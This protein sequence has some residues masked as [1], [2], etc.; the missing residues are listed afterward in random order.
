MTGNAVLG[1]CIDLPRLAREDGGK[2]KV[3]L[4]GPIGRVHNAVVLICMSVSMYRY[5]TRKAEHSL[6]AFLYV[7]AQM[8]DLG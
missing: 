6:L 1:G 5:T 2:K 4:N 7:L 8:N 3:A